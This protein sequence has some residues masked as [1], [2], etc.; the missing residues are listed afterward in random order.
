[1][2]KTAQG[3]LIRPPHNVVTNP[4]HYNNHPSGIEAIRILRHYPANIF[5]AMKYLWRSEDK[6]GTEDLRKAIWHIADQ[7]D[8]LEGN[9]DKPTGW[10]EQ[11]KAAMKAI[12]K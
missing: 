2:G 5:A 11:L 3:K 9:S 10:G 6:N 8:L 7:I 12:K 4:K 1:M